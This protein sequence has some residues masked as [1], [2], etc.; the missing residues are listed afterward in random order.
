MCQ[1]YKQAA[2]KGCIFQSYSAEDM[3]EVGQLKNKR[4]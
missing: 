1:Q 4:F 2:N 3:G